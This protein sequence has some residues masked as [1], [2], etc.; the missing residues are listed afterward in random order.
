MTAVFRGWGFLTSSPAAIWRTKLTVSGFI[1]LAPR[2]RALKSLRLRF[3]RWC[4]IAH[5]PRLATYRQLHADNQG[6]GQGSDME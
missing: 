6:F 5:H 1:L 2:R 4:Q 3:M